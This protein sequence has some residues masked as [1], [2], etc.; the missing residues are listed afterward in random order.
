MRSLRQPGPIHPRRI[1]VVYGTAQKLRYTLTPGLTLTEAVTGPLIEAGFQSG[2][3]VI[4]DAILSPFRFVMPGPPDSAAHVAY[5]SAAVEPAGPVRIEQANVTFGWSSG[6]PLIHVHAAWTEADGRRRGGHILPTETRIGS[7][8]DV[9]AWGFSDI[10][11]ET[12]ADPETNFSLLQPVP[13]ANPG[14][15]LFA[16]VKPNQD[17]ISALEEIAAAAGLRNATIRGSLGSLIGADFTDG[18]TIEDLATEVF[19]R[20][21]FIQDGIASLSLTAVDFKGEPRSGWIKRNENPVCIT[22][23]IILTPP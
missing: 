3:V 22:F 4:K 2:A 10:R 6:A 16:R 14:P 7:P 5:F 21:G 13:H 9:I 20:E 18:G 19:V 8:A 17:I 12:S 11:I 23:D 1:D 15:A